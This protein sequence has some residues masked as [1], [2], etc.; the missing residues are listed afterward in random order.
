MIEVERTDDGYAVLMIGHA[1]NT[2]QKERTTI[3]LANQGLTLTVAGSAYAMRQEGKLLAKIPP[4]MVDSFLVEPGVEIT[5]KAL[6]L[7]GRLGIPMTFL[8]HCGEARNRL[9]PPWKY[10]PAPRIAQTRTL[11]DETKRLIVARELVSAK[12]HNQMMVL[13]KYLQN[14]AC[15]EVR[16]ARNELRRLMEKILPYTRTVEETMGVEGIAAKTYFGALGHLLRIDWTEFSG[17][18]R[19][20]P[21]D[22]VNAALSYAYAILTNQIHSLL[23]AVGLD[24]YVGNLHA[25]VARRPSLALDL[26]EP[27]RPALADR[28]V[29]RFFNQRQLQ[30]EDFQKESGLS[31]AIHLRLEARK[32]LIREMVSWMQRCDDDLGGFRAPYKMMIE[33][34]EHYRNCLRD[35]AAHDFRA[36]RLPEK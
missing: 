3:Y 14:Y 4:M 29:V 11:L 12:L 33:N 32:K 23:E 35:D 20:P 31:P 7:T 30:E 18:N 24:P 6:E 36:F 19:R 28:M 34:V 17:R 10:D 22:P 16:A 15:E 21:R 27:F 13:R 2:M 26:M 5:R 8:D 25:C 1:I 9:V